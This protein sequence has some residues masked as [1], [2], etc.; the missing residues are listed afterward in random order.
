MAY[1]R[2]K[3]SNTAVIFLVT[4]IL[5]SLWQWQTYLYEV[6]ATYQCDLIKQTKNKLRGL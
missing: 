6:C 3:Q 2:P 4:F 1:T 5:Q